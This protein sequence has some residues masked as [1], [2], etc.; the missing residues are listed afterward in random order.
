MFGI[1]KGLDNR[2][3]KLEDE[4]KSLA[5]II[6][7]NVKS[8]SKDEDSDAEPVDSEN[9]DKIIFNLNFSIEDDEI[10][11]EM[12]VNDYSEDSIKKIG[13]FFGTMYSITMLNE[14]LLLLKEELDKVDPKLFIE[15]AQT[16]LLVSREKESKEDDNPVVLPSE[17]FGND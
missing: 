12:R 9:G 3:N 8:F 16:A 11:T 14:T 17:F 2:M 7:E 4:L 10:V 5:Q 6:A 13:I 1:N 15:I